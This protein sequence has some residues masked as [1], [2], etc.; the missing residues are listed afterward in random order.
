MQTFAN[1]HSSGP[2]ST[3]ISGTVSA[4]LPT[5]IQQSVSPAATFG[6]LAIWQ[7]RFRLSSWQPAKAL[8]APA[9]R[10]RPVTLSLSQFGIAVTT[11]GHH[12]PQMLTDTSPK[13]Q[14][15]NKTGQG[16]LKQRQSVPHIPPRTHLRQEN[17]TS[18]NTSNFIDTLQGSPRTSDANPETQNHSMNRHQKSDTCTP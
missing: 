18:P 13:H 15:D 4:L 11:G 3:A 14:K 1:Y 7:L 8:P 5:N 6:T 17:T 2:R 16:Q 10:N 12:M 9:L